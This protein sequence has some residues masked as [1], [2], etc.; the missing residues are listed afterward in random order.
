MVDVKSQV[1]K[2]N[3]PSIPELK[4]IVETKSQLCQTV[5]ETKNKR[6]DICR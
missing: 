4:E 1:C 3:Q 5:I 6:V 2:T